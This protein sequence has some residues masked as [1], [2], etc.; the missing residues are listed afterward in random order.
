[1][2]GQASPPPLSHPLSLSRPWGR[3]L[4]RLMAMQI[5]GKDNYN[6]AVQTVAVVASC[7]L[8]R[9][10]GYICDICAMKRP[11]YIVRTTYHAMHIHIC[12]YCT[13]ACVYVSRKSIVQS[14]RGFSWKFANN[15]LMF[16]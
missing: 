10:S 4:G 3:L 12:M 6:I 8:C 13:Y 7:R 11:I 15:S 14:A 16:N 2:S 1:M 9:L 5:Y